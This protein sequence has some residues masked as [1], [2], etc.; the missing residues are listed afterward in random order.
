VSVDAGDGGVVVSYCGCVEK[1]VTKM[2]PRDVDPFSDNAE[3][4][5][6]EFRSPPPGRV[7]LNAWSRGIFGGTLVKG[8]LVYIGFIGLTVLVAFAVAAFHH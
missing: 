2:A 8:M 3:F 1:G 7:V 4:D 5:E 6:G